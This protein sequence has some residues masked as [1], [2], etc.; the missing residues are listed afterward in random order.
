MSDESKQAR[1]SRDPAQLDLAEPAT[2]PS[3]LR[4]WQYDL[5]TSSVL[6]AGTLAI[7]IAT[8]IGFEWVMVAV[9]APGWVVWTV[10]PVMGVAFLGT[11][12]VAV[13]SDT[14]MFILRRVRDLLAEWRGS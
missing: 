14:A 1:D 3:P 5:V 8:G 10:R 11:M 4:P 9:R 7:V 12:T 2:Q 6:T 13:L